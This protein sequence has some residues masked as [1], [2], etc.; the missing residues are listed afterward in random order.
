MKRRAKI[1]AT[2]GPASSGRENLSQLFA[3]GIDIARL[4]FSHGSHANHKSV[5]RDLRTLATSLDQPISIIAD[6]QGPKIRVGSIL[7]GSITL[8]QNEI[9]TL[10]SEL[11]Q[12][13]DQTIPIDFPGFFNSI[14][15]GDRILMDDGNL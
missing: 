14:S 1:V 15:P 10:T 9:V 2:I 4:N 12:P 3:A 11:N 5:Y 6:I 7:E 13:P 8:V